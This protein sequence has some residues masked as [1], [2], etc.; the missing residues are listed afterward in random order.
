MKSEKHRREA[1]QSLTWKSIEQKFH[2]WQ[3]FKLCKVVH[4]ENYTDKANGHVPLIVENVY[5]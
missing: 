4:N 3:K 1:H 2:S 5:F